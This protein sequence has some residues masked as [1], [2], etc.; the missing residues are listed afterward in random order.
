MITSQRTL[1]YFVGEQAFK[2][3][4]DAQKADLLALMPETWEGATGEAL[5]GLVAD[6]LLKNCKSI[7]DT[8]TTTPKSRLRA[9]KSH[10]AVRKPRTSKSPPAAGHENKVAS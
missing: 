1:F 3:L 6:W 4:E 9:R 2:S 7:V 5:N 8:L 10:G